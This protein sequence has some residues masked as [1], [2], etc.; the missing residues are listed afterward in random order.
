M[1]N[2]I[3][4][5]PPKTLRHWLQVYLLYRKAFPA[6]ERKPFSIILNMYRKGKTDLWCICNGRQF[7]GFASTVNGGSLILLDYF[8][9]SPN[10]RGCGIGTEALLQLIKHYSGLGL[11]VEIE[12]TAPPGTD[13]SQRI[14]RKEF[15]LQCGM[16]DLKVTANVFGVSMEL[17]GVN[18]Q[19]D[20]PAYKDFYRT[21]YSPWAAEH[22][23]PYTHT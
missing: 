2:Q 13:Q 1:E 18:C 4:L 3:T 11:F 9:V 10:H 15:Y 7:A 19:L 21:Y 14:R 20:F 5:S 22:I 6:S 12:N 16:K 8:A 17:L 23:Q